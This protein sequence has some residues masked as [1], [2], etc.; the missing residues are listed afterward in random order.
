MTQKVNTFVIPIVRSDLI[1]RCLETLYANTPP[2]FYVF[3]IDQTVHGLDPKLRDRF[4]DLMIIRPP[5]TEVHTTGNLGFAKGTNLGIMLVETPYFTMCNDDVEFVHPGWWEGVMETFV[6]VAQQTPD[7]P[8]IIVNPSSI[9]LPDWS[10]G[11][12]AGEHHHILPYKDK[13]TDKD[14]KKLIEEPHYI[15]ERLT[16]QPGSV[17]DGI[18][19]YCSVADT[20]RFLDVG[21]LDEQYYPGGAEDYDYSCRASLKGYRSVG[22]THSYVWHHWSKTLSSVEK[23][24]IKSL[25]QDDLRFGD[26]E[27]KWG[28]RFDIWGVKCDVEGCDQRLRTFDNKV[29]FCPEHPE[30]EFKIP[31]A[32]IRPL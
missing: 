7:R 14:W 29:A 24:E 21:L 2:N 17:I 13:Y 16:I 18:T 3:V 8:A 28:P 1:E 10:I 4:Q 20:R 15:N 19:L 12:P 30:N 31:E 23:A 27:K 25:I 5:K 32:I 22:T 26:Q 9:K 11:A 6:K